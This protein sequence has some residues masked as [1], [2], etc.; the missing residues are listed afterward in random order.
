MSASFGHAVDGAARVDEQLVGDRAAVDDRVAPVVEGDPLR[1]QLGAEPV[2]VAGDRIDRAGAR[3]RRRTL[4]ASREAQR[5]RRRQAR[6]GPALVGGELL[7]EDA[8]PAAEEA[9]GAVGQVAGAAAGQIP[10][11]ALERRLRARERS[12][13]TAAARSSA[14]A[15]SP[16][17]HGPHW[18]A[19]CSAS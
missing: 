2:P 18:P 7:G 4:P 5:R 9:H 13:A 12:P 10:A 8:H 1:E 3:S 16:L 17:L 11:P 14:I 6:Q 15:G 19:L